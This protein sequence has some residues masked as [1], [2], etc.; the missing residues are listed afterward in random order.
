MTIAEQMAATLS[1]CSSTIQISRLE[2]DYL[3]STTVTDEDELE[4]G[5]LSSHSENRLERSLKKRKIQDFAP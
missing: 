5:S 2:C 1:P 4:C 3:S